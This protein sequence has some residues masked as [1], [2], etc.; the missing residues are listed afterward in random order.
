MHSQFA[1]MV[2]LEC[3]NGSSVR[4]WRALKARLGSRVWQF[5]PKPK[6]CTDEI[7]IKRVQQAIQSLNANHCVVQLAVSYPPLESR[8]TRLIIRAGEPSSSKWLEVVNGVGRYG[9]ITTVHP[10][11]A[12]SGWIDVST[13]S[14]GVHGVMDVLAS[15]DAHLFIPAMPKQI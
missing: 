13:T 14:Q 8:L 4:I 15:S 3:S 6:C 10:A 9:L 1:R 5:V 7:G 11:S 12:T 2:A